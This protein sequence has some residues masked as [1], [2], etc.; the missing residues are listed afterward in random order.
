MPP[1]PPT[2]AT[3]GRTLPG[4][5]AADQNVDQKIRD[6]RRMRIAATLLLA[7]MTVL[8]VATSLAM[9]AWPQL[10]Y[11][12]AFAE[13]AMVGACA[14]WFAV[15][16]LFRRPLGLPIPHTGIVPRNKER[17]GGAL[18]R[19]MSNN[20]LS[21]SVLAKRLDKVEAAQWAAAWLNNPGNAR[22]IAG[23]ASRF[24]PQILGAL[25]RD[26]LVDWFAK[27]ALRGIEALPAA[28]LASKILSL[29]WAQGETQALLNRAIELAEASLVS[30]KDL[31]R[32]KV[33]QNSSRLIPKWID[34]MLADKV[35]NGLQST[36]AEMRNAEHPW[37]VELRG[38]IETLIFDLANNPD[39]RAR[40]ESMKAEWLANPVFVAQVNELCQDVEAQLNANVSVHAASVAAGLEFALLALGEWL[41]E[42]KKI[43]ARLNRWARRA[44]LRALAPR[45]AEIGAYIANVVENWDAT[46]LVNRLELQVGRDLQ[47]IRINGTLVGGLVGLLIFVASKWLTPV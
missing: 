43:Q 1:P 18:G 46:T 3:K 42:D 14:D 31:I 44:A 40:G 5:A 34:G 36:L 6:L 38:A 45:R 21:P 7:L 8:F 27:A 23:Q 4:L 28:P 22:Q 20:F 16:A 39:M 15:V 9:T 12:R 19:F 30:H 35:M 25:P 13:A 41:R 26:Q 24:L 10:A 32:A 17:I 2:R 11:I 47:Y 37:R 29:L 33:T